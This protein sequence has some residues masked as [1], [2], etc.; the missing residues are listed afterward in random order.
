MENRRGR[1]RRVKG[2]WRRKR[3]LLHRAELLE[4]IVQDIHAN[5]PDHIAVTGDL[6]NLSLAGEYA[7]ARAW[8]ETVGRPHDVTLVPGNHDA[9]VPEAAKWPQLYWGEYMRGDA[10]EVGFPFVRRRGPLALVGLSSA[11]ASP[12]FWA[13]GVSP[14]FFAPP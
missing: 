14:V 3:H 8:L 10:G 13:T 1:P 12:P 6:V 9:Y 5:A 4:R 7:P 2:N 11:G